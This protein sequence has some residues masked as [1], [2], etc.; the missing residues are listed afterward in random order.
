MNKK[1]QTYIWGVKLAWKIDKKMLMYWGFISVMI[2]VFPALIL[3]YYRDVLSVISEFMK[4][5]TSDDFFA[6][7]SRC[8]SLIDLTSSSCAL[9]GSI[10]SITS[11]LVV[12]AV[13]S[14]LICIFALS[15]VIFVLGVN[16]MASERVRVVWKELR[17]HLRKADYI[18]NLV[19]EGDT[20][21]EVRIFHNVDML[22]ASW[23][24]ARGKADKMKLQ[25]TVWT[26]RINLICQAGYY[27]FLIIIMGASLLRLSEGIIKPDILLMLFTL[28]TQIGENAEKIPYAYQRLDYGIYGLELQKSFFEQ[29]PSAAPETEA[30]KTEAPA[31]EEV[32]F[33]AEHVSFSYPGGK[34]VLDDISFSINR[35]ETI[36]L[37]GINGS[38]KTTLL[39]L[40]MGLYHPASG[41]LKFQGRNY[42]EYCQGYLIKKVG[43]FFQDFAL[44]HLTVKE[45]VGLGNIDCMDDEKMIWN[46]L[47]KGGVADLVASWENGINQKLM[48]N[49]YRDGIIL[50]GGESQRIAVARTHMS[51]R[52]IL[53][54]DEPASMLDPI[55]ELEQFRHIK[56]KIQG[57]T[58][59]LVSHRIGFAQLADRIFV[60]NQGKIALPL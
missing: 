45:N 35:G 48:K 37:V 24:A 11:I 22:K 57:H 54:F 34:K 56:E 31:D 14:P 30:L 33:Q 55:A 41:K 53:I 50:S 19:Q 9:L 58:S 5:E 29:T 60:L 13:V 16:V 25:Q 51:D 27:I 8:G 38:G 46:A 43:S 26:A 1:I 17:E 59:I 6:A 20:A 28:G 36:A 12:A 40:L 3:L 39:K 21:K 15:Y 44:F 7:I 47:K 42:D 10:V 52:E 23:E 4:K 2:S 49:V 18:R 32:C